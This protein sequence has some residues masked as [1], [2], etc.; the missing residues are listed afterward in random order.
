MHWNAIIARSSDPNLPTDVSGALQDASKELDRSAGSSGHASL[1][2]QSVRWLGVQIR[3]RCPECFSGKNRPDSIAH[4]LRY[5]RVWLVALAVLPL[6]MLGLRIGLALIDRD[7][8]LAGSSSYL[9]TAAFFCI[10][11]GMSIGVWAA[12]IYRASHRRRLRHSLRYHH[13]GVALRSFIAKWDNP[14]RTIYR[15]CRLS[16]RVAR[17]H[18]VQF[19]GMIGCFAA[20]GCLAA[21]THTDS[22]V[23]DI[24]CMLSTM[25][26]LSQWPT[27]GRLVRWCGR[28]LDPLYTHRD[29]Y[30]EY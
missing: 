10:A 30:I 5:L 16:A 19:F 2:P 27:S 23:G 13:R 4:Q 28:V 8:L 18:D 15:S 25:A 14:S 12:P 24:L 17:V 11:L 29:E 1:G 3:R 21:L 6:A 22:F 20:A 26:I 7:A 9:L